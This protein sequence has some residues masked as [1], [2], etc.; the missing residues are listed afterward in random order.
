MAHKDTV[1]LAFSRQALTVLSHFQ[2]CPDRLWAAGFR[3][4]SSALLLFQCLL[5]N[6]NTWNSSSRKKWKVSNIFWYAFGKMMVWQ[7]VNVIR[8]QYKVDTD[9]RHKKRAEV[10]LVWCWVHHFI[11]VS[12]SVLEVLWNV[13]FKCVI[14]CLECTHWRRIYIKILERSELT[15]GHEKS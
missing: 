6:S 1:V 2:F 14:K 8:H 12:G 7:T 3:G 5:Q 15:E 11:H 9:S 4:W 13:H 10:H